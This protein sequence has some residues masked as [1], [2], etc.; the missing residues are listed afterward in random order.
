MVVGWHQ[1]PHIQHCLQWMPK[2][3]F[4]NWIHN[5]MTIC[6]YETQDLAWWFSQFS[7]VSIM[8]SSTLSQVSKKNHCHSNWLILNH[9]NWIAF[10]LPDVSQLSLKLVD[11][12]LCRSAFRCL[13]SVTQI[14]CSWIGGWLCTSTGTLLN[15]NSEP[16]L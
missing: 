9:N 3:E 10:Q 11:L 7:F 1:W 6:F 13:S 15:V 5:L 8:W 4:G 2:Y 16:Y 12:E 14:C